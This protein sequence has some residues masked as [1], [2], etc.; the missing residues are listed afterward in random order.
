MS[1]FATVCPILLYDLI[2]IIWP[3]RV[4]WWVYYLPAFFRWFCIFFPW[5]LLF[6]QKKTLNQTKSPSIFLLSFSLITY[7][8]QL[9]RLGLFSFWFFFGVYFALFFYFL[10]S[11]FVGSFA[12]RLVFWFIASFS[13]AFDFYLWSIPLA[14]LL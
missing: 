13:I 1:C 8:L 12:V 14:F 6:Q 2:Y 5:S 7:H 11:L 3:K 9:D 10:L 4:H